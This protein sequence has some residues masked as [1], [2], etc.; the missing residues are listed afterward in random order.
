MTS[1]T[2]AP[3][4]TTVPQLWERQVKDRGA[5]E[6]LVFEDARSHDVCRFTYREF[7]A[8]VNKCAN[9]LVARG[10]GEG[11][12]VVLYLDNCVEF[13]ECTLALAKMGAVSVPVD[14]TSAP[15][16][17]GRILGLCQADT[18]ITRACRVGDVLFCLPD[19]VRDV[20]VVGQVGAADGD[21]PD[22]PRLGEL[23]SREADTFTS[24]PR[25]RPKDLCEILFTSGTTSA[26]KGV[27]ITH[28]NFV[29]SGNFVNWELDMN[30]EDRYMTSM[31]AAR[32]NLQLSALAPVLTMGATL[33]MLSRYRATCFW[34]QARDHRATLVQG[35]AMIVVTMLRQS[36]D[37]GERDHQV[38]EMHYFLPLNKGD[39]AAF[40][41]RFGV[42]LLNNYGSTECL[43]GAITDYPHGE[44]RW[45]SIGRV[46]PGYEVRIVDCQGDELPEGEVGEIV[47]RGVPGVSLMAG[48]W[49]DPEA[50]AEVLDED[51]WFH[52]H[53]YAYIENGW[54]YFMDRRVDLIKRSGESVSSAE[55]EC[56]IDGLP[57]VREVAVIGVP[58]GVR[59]QA[60]KA[61]VVAE[62][63]AGLDAEAVIDHCAGRLAGFKVP[64]FVEFVEELPRGSYGKVKKHILAHS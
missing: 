37:P 54:V 51:G 12:R 6:F 35:M 47:L 40:E 22:L 26:P 36:V 39:K 4:S 20:I 2:F 56:I 60:V 43:I 24:N 57:G 9:A 27:M 5:H 7:D 13:I 25:V 16:E 21:G 19:T 23:T 59:G 45:P 32:V 34:R 55:V 49:N 42:P 63:E 64:S 61:F 62:P 15:F 10:I 11:S 50:T 31:V 52:T 29:F 44:R 14:A 53:D 28:A 3:E 41:E 17:L 38:R 30:P 58:D 1:S 18:L 48:Y 46:G 33:I 8:A